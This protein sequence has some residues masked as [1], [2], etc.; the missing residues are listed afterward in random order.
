MLSDDK[1]WLIILAGPTAIGKT[2][3]AVEIAQRLNTSIIGCDSRQFYKELNIGTAPPS[4]EQLKKVKHYFVHFLSI[5]DY[6]NVS[7]YENDVNAKLSEIFQTNKAVVLV[8]GS[9]LYIDAVVKGIDDMPDIDVGLRNELNHQLSEKGVEWLRAQLQ[10]LDYETYQKIDLKNKNRI[11]RAVEV[12]LQ[13]GMPYS[14]FLKRQS[15][16]RPYKMLKIALDMPREL[17]YE[18]INSRVDNMIN[19]G[20]VEEAK[21]Y[22]PFKNLVA[23]KT[24]GYKELFDYFENKSTL[25]EA[26]DL[27]KRNTRK[28]ARKQ[29]TWLRKDKDY[30]WFHP[31]EKEQ[32]FRFIQS[33]IK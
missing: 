18:R 7:K 12:C 8:G 10:K 22:Y 4:D 3:L 26:I 2:D 11:L 13:T 24:V 14:S 5:H 19:H 21:L 17:L 31:S 28:Y 33:K 16:D 23:L 25:E 9:G 6:Y 15:K 30:H 20:L 27:I 32:I 1:P 29:L